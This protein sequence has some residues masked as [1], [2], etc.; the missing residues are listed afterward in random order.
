MLASP[1]KVRNT[2]KGEQGHLSTLARFQ[3]LQRDTHKGSYEDERGAGP[4]REGGEDEDEQRDAGTADDGQHH[5]VVESVSHL[6]VKQLRAA[7][8]HLHLAGASEEERE[9]DL[10]SAAETVVDVQ[11]LMVL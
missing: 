3:T 7:V 11:Q 2:V 8:Q 4:T 6:V 9:R 10:T 1:K 5:V